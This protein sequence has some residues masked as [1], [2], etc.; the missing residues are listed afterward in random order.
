MSTIHRTVDQHLW[1]YAAAAVFAGAVLALMILTLRT[2]GS[3]TSTQPDTENAPTTFHHHRVIGCHAG[4]PVPNIE[5]PG[6]TP[7]VR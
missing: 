3:V 4:H 2:T 5:L 6:C 1:W 7:R